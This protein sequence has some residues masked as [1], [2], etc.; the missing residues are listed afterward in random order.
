MSMQQ[1]KYHSGGV[2]PEEE[3][4]YQPNA[5]NK[6]RIELTAYAMCLSLLFYAKDTQSIIWGHNSHCKIS[7]DVNEKS[8]WCTQ[9]LINTE[10]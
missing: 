4:K 2:L 10:K 9:S 6:V 8:G 5:K 3:L 7:P 1:T